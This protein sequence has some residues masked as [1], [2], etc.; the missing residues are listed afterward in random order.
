MSGNHVTAFNALQRTQPRA[1]PYLSVRMTSLFSTALHQIFRT[2]FTRSNTFALILAPSIGVHHTVSD[3]VTVPLSKYFIIKNTVLITRLCSRCSFW[4][5]RTSQDFYIMLP[6]EY[7]LSVIQYPPLR[8]LCHL[9]I[10][11]RIPSLLPHAV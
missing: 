5:V 4:V 2:S 3:C 11:Y 7:C 1:P 9:Y 10:Y 8:R 6:C